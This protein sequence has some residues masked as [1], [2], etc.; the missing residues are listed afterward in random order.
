MRDSKGTQALVWSQTLCKT[1]ATDVT[2]RAC[3][4][5]TASLS[6]S[7]LHPS[8]LSFFL[9]PFLPF[10]LTSSS[11]SRVSQ[12]GQASLSLSLSQQAVQTALVSSQVLLMLFLVHCRHITA[13][14]RRQLRS[15]VDMRVQRARQ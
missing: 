1:Q 4:A 14:N 5:S 13:A 2:H 11:F 9:L 8:V 3:T 6:M 15:R 10:P 12:D 7:L